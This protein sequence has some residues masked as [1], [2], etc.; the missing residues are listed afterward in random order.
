MQN[1]ILRH[2]DIRDALIAGANRIAPCLILE[3]IPGKVPTTTE[4]REM[5]IDSIWPTVEDANSQVAK[6]GRVP[7]E[8]ILVATPDKP[9]LRTGKMSIMRSKTIELFSDD[10]DILYMKNAVGLLTRDLPTIPRL[11]FESILRLYTAPLCRSVGYSKH[12][13]GRQ[14]F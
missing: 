14:R 7:K 12:R 6:F 2:P 5:I 8:L 9:F 4:Q 10:M 1:E 13:T 11:D 3:M